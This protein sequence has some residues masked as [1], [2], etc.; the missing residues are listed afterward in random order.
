MIISLHQFSGEQTATQTLACHLHKQTKGRASGSALA[1]EIVLENVSSSAIEIPIRMSPLQH[2]NLIVTD[3]RQRIV[4]TG[5]YGDLFSPG[6]EDRVV[7]LLPGEKYVS[8]VSLLATVP[9]DQRRPGV[10]LI[11]AVYETDGIRAVSLPYRLDWHPE[12]DG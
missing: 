12:Q 2:L 5:H 10:Y 8:N 11:Q 4:S 7:R 6:T 3:S 9:V 1:G